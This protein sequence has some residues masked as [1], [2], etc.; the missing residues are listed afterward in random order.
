[1][2]PAAANLPHSPRTVRKTHRIARMVLGVSGGAHL[3]ERLLDLAA[4]VLC[5]KN[6]G[7]HVRGNR[8]SAFLCTRFEKRQLAI[9]HPN[10]ENGSLAVEPAFKLGQ[11]GSPATAQGHRLALCP[12]GFNGNNRCGNG[13]CRS[14]LSQRR[15]SDCGR[16]GTHRGRPFC[17]SSDLL[18]WQPG[19]ETW[20]IRS[21]RRGSLSMPAGRMRFGFG[22]RGLLRD[23]HG[24][25]N[26]LGR[27]PECLRFGLLQF[28]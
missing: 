18:D 22:R 15:V 2:T 9:G 28:G 13:C 12:S 14:S 25:R 24:N 26:R 27:G 21:C 10:G 11:G 17:R 8:D 23:R 16:R 5:L 20:R 3:R 7:T 6:A 1:M 4:Q 19:A